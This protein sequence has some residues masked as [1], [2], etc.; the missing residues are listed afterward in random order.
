MVFGA[1]SRN[2]FRLATKIFQKLTKK[3][4][5]FCLYFNFISFFPASV[6]AKIIIKREKAIIIS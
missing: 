6:I 2:L 3:K 1:G 4:L 5:D